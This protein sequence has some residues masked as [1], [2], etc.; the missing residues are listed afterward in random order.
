MKP[1]LCLVSYIVFSLELLCPW[2]GAFQDYD[3]YLYDYGPPRTDLASKNKVETL[4]PVLKRHVQ[5]LRGAQDRRMDIVFLVD[6]SASVGMK[7]F[8][9]ELKFVRK[10]LADFTVD[11]NH[12]RVA[13]VTFSSRTRVLRQ[14]DYIASQSEEK[15]KCSLLSEDLPSI[16]YV[17]GGTYTL[18]AILEAKE[19]LKH[20]RSTS[21]KAVFL[22]TDGF[23]NGGD[24]RFEARLLRESGVKMFT[25]G[26][27]NGNVLELQDMA[28][29]PKNETC[30]ILDS[31]E[32]FE[33]LARRALHEDLRSGSYLK[34]T[35]DKCRGL[36]NGATPCCDS[37]AI[38]RCGTH[39][40]TYECACQLGYYGSGVS[41]D[42]HPCPPGTYKSEMNPG[43]VSSCKKCPDENHITEIGST[44]ASDCT[45]KRGF[46]DFNTTG[47]AALRLK[48]CPA[49]PKPKN[50]NMICDRDD[51]S[52]ST[53]CRFTCDSGYKLV[54]SRKRECL[55][56]SFWTGITTRC[57][58]IYCHPLPKIED[59]NITPALCTDKDVIFGTVCQIECH[60][61]YTL[62]G[63]TS[64]QCT[65]EGLWAPSRDGFCEDAS[66]PIVLCPRDIS[67]VADDEESTANVT[68]DEP[69]TFDNSGVHPSIKTVP[70][71]PDLFP[72]GLTYVK[73]IAVD[74]NGN[75]A[76]CRFSVEV[77]DVTP[78]RVDRCY[79]PAPFVS[80]ALYANV[81]WEEPVFTD[82]SEETPRIERSHAP[83]L[84]PRGKT[85]VTYTAFDESGNNSTCDI[86]ITVVAH[87]CQYPPEPINGRR[88][89]RKA[90]DGVYCKVACMRGYAF[91]ISPAEEYYCHYDNKWGPEENLPIPDC[92]VQTAS[93]GIIQPASITFL[94]SVPCRR[95]T[96]IN[97]IEQTIEVRVSQRVSELCA[98]NVICE[99]EDMQT[100]CEEE[101]D[102]NVIRIILGR[103]R[104]DTNEVTEVRRVNPRGDNS[105]TSKDSSLT[106]D[107]K[108]RGASNLIYRPKKMIPF[109]QMRPTGD[110][111]KD[112]QR[113]D[114]LTENFEKI[115]KT[116]NTEAKRGV[117]DIQVGGATVQFSN[118]SFDTK[119]P[120]FNCKPGSILL[121]TSCVQC[122][123]GS[124]FNVISE[125]CEGCSLGS[126]Q[127]IVGAVSC[128]VCPN[129]TSTNF[130]NSKS[131][132][133]CKAKCLPGTF[134][135]TGL[136]R[137][138][139]CE[140]GFYQP[141]YGQTECLKC[142]PD[143]TTWK[144]G[145]RRIQKCKGGRTTDYEEVQ[146]D[147]SPLNQ[148]PEIAIN[149][150]FSNQCQNGGTCVSQELGYTC[151]C[152][153]GYRGNNC[154]E[155]INECEGKPCLNNGTC[156]D[157]LND[158]SCTCHP[159]YEGKKCEEN[160]D[161]CM[162]APCNNNGTCVDLVND[163]TCN[164]PDG[165]E[166]PTCGVMKDLCESG[167]CMNDGSCRSLVGGYECSCLTGFEGSNC[168]INIQECSSSPCDNGASCVDGIGTFRC[169][170]VPGY[171]GKQCQTE[172]DEC[173]SSPC[174]GDA[175]CVDA[176]DG[177]V[178]R[179]K[180]GFAGDLC[181]RDQDLTALTASF[182]MRTDAQ[183]QGT[184]FSYASS[185]Q[186]SNA[187]T[188][189]NY[190][191][192][193]IYIN[194]KSAV[195]DVE[196]NDGEWHHVVFTW[197]ANRGAWKI[198]FDSLSWDS[199]EN[200]AAYETIK[201]GG[202]FVVGQEQDPG[203]VYSSS[204]AFVGQI[205]RINIWDEE[206]PL[207]V[208]ENMRISCDKRIGNVIAWPD[209]QMGLH[210]S[211]VAE[212]SNFCRGCQ[213]P[214]P[215]T[216]GKVNFAD[217]DAGT[218]ASYVCNTGYFLTGRNSRVCLIT[219]DWEGYPPNCLPVDCGYPGSVDNGFVEGNRFQYDSRV[220]YKCEKGYRLIGDRTLYCNSSG[221]WEGQR[222]FG[223]S[224]R[225]QCN[226]GYV[227]DDFYD[228]IVCT[229]DGSWDQEPPSCRPVN[230]GDPGLLI[231][232]IA[233]AEQTTFGSYVTYQCDPGYSLSGSNTRACLSNSSWG[234]VTPS[235]RP[236]SC[237]A[238]SRIS[239][240]F[241]IGRDYTFGNTVT[242]AC[243]AGFNLV[244]ESDSLC[245]ANGRWSVQRPRCRRKDCKDPPTIPHGSFTEDR[246]VFGDSVTYTCEFGYEIVENNSTE[247]L[248]DTEWKT[249][250]PRCEPISCG[251]LEVIENGNY[252]STSFT[253]GGLVEFYCDEGFILKGESI[254]ICQ[255]YGYW[256]G[257][258]P[259]CE[260]GKCRAP[261]LID[262]GKVDY[263]DLSFKS[264]V[265]YS[266]NAGYTLN[267]LDVR[268]CQ[269]N[270]TLSGEEPVCLPKACR[271]PG[272]IAHG[273]KS[274]TGLLFNSVVTYQCD[275]GY[276]LRGD[277]RLT[278]NSN[279]EWSG[280]VPS[281]ELVECESPSR[282]T[283][284][285]R[286][287][288]DDFSYGATISY[289]CDPGYNL[290]GSK[291]RTCQDNGEWDEKIPICE[292]VQCR[293]PTI[294][295]GFPSGFRTE[296]NTRISFSCR[297][298]Y[299]LFGPSERRCL[300]NGTWSGPD[301]VCVK[302]AQPPPVNFGTV[303]IRNF[304]TAVYQCN[305]NFILIGKSDLE[306]QI[307]GS[308]NGSPPRC[309]VMGCNS[310]EL[311]I[312]S[313]RSGKVNVSGNGRDS[314]A[315]YICDRGYRLLGESRRQCS[316]DGSWSGNAPIC[317]IVTCP[318]SFSIR[319]GRILGSNYTYRSNLTFECQ[320]NY[321]LVGEQYITCQEN[322]LWSGNA[323]TCEEITC[324]SLDPLPFGRITVAS[325]SVGS[326]AIYTCN[327][328]YEIRELS[329]SQAKR[330]CT[331]DGLW[332]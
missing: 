304:K 331:V 175:T 324:P 33:A 61:G 1:K 166:G 20:S 74:S 6:S 159:G 253:S 115:L 220:R 80:S 2:G 85:I 213:I 129:N 224:A 41:F 51:F 67:V 179:C 197:S 31:F 161:E 135:P 5:A 55:A 99:V 249:P 121:N 54:G 84:F 244:G 69:V 313:F 142:P 262:N 299:A 190:Q 317:L 255:P 132:L 134:S 164:C 329:S 211:L 93:N 119:T 112:F 295:N 98:D 103:K 186:I 128:L 322:G 215:P 147:E 258:Q 274:S 59:G 82:N 200:L 272:D 94:S 221:E 251:E 154:E 271:D 219:G 14:V 281:C 153:P 118:M 140:R 58:E 21:Q 125:E 185:D 323:P 139:T 105:R 298:G 26:I 163:Y 172:I 180:K 18:G 209:L 160:V 113:Q 63:P 210:G 4:G 151:N 56:I 240:G 50:G 156:K 88:E 273:T 174:P 157:L 205:T 198:Y 70:V 196:A 330:T 227:S 290:V 309:E 286:M 264:V 87:P 40:G 145:A 226:D 207:S 39:T 214:S 261:P 130:N 231:N 183:N 294:R 216:N 104:R 133:E 12:T 152:V 201:G 312:Q 24:P 293:R 308:W 289:E 254:R 268:R 32:E 307:N 229:V 256:S 11:S 195:T 102:F 235:C 62:K 314:I 148:Q 27:R 230:C 325:I 306:C 65:T 212:P 23:S 269:Q 283:S 143:S 124:F 8:L 320:E 57:R 232:G 291:N 170:C 101:E 78:P 49:L 48:T 68:W 29:E 303:S 123:R 117:L 167:P 328:G 71:P 30:Y 16:K 181:E 237:G 239:N 90:E 202:T 321:R 177:F 222:P 47:C 267:G 238:P 86:E 126:Y 97:T 257:G 60:Q 77:R 141:E 233:R 3:Q 53:E 188:I 120:S 182:W 287:I 279:S 234:G 265:I 228:E 25:F 64:K 260:P 95:R 9:D 275:T 217:T 241:Y 178:C 73:Y 79:S 100:T 165:F 218:T 316:E 131:Q 89:C 109:S 137:C 248:S 332:S 17:G 204:E 45:C 292:V 278:C 301:P 288:G 13:V 7:N 114:N 144:R 191:G 243:D 122:P 296:Y 127:P 206:L 223:S 168:E 250:I 199:G 116:I 280:N 225:Y 107:F 192:F 282:V 42:C 155:E 38:C 184:P 284:N 270:L 92:S 305:P 176:I 327:T 106:F 162:S 76:K 146:A 15:H 263:K 169:I 138:E 136:E 108:L 171:T 187:L 150:C 189:T 52:F 326:E 315:E 259:T 158:F 276:T 36:C 19:I 173:A 193:V 44:D 247:C 75:R 43:D 66:P 72:I 37:R 83:G 34:Q 111:V 311:N 302:C 318:G 236:V 46:R 110:V 266:C 246:Y 81:S 91:A 208:I 310:S 297:R 252:T 300:E 22:I 245:Q 319:N 10:L 194:D 285:G 203:G 96:L 277:A 28:S 35:D 149:D 242:Y